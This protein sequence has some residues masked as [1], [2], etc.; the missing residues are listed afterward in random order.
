MASTC[1][2]ATWFGH[3]SSTGVECGPAAPVSSKNEQNRSRF[4]RDVNSSGAPTQWLIYTQVDGG[5]DC[6]ADPR[7]EDEDDPRAAAARATYAADAVARFGAVGREIA[8]A[9]FGPLDIADRGSAQNQAATTNFSDEEKD[10]TAQD[11]LAIGAQ[12]GLYRGY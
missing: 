5:S 11:M 4:G 9:D 10:Q 2:D 6:D 1:V 12:S 7:D 3:D 8:A